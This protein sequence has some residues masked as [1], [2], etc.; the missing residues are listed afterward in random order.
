M[1]TILSVDA[2]NG[3][4]VAVTPNDVI[5]PIILLRMNQFND[6]GITFEEAV[7]RIRSDLIPDGYMATPFRRTVPEGHVDRLR[8][9]LATFTF[10]KEVNKLRNLNKLIN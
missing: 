4:P 3:L 8:S 7:Q 1:C 9:I 6:D 5:P 2:D 10:R